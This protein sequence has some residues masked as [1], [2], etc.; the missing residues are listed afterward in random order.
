MRKLPLF[1]ESKLQQLA[2]LGLTFLLT[3]G[4]IKLAF[5]ARIRP[6]ISDQ[7]PLVTFFSCPLF[8]CFIANSRRWWKRGSFWAFTGLMAV[9]HLLAFLNLLRHPL[10]FRSWIFIAAFLLELGL[11]IVLRNWLLPKTG[12]VRQELP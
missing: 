4:A 3:A 12:I 8:A 2:V 1:L 11:L 10:I 5:L 6:E 7:I 9:T